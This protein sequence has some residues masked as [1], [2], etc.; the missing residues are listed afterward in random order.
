MK[1][2]EE[3]SLEKEKNVKTTSQET[4]IP[5]RAFLST[6]ISLFRSSH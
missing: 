3:A 6:L 2:K 4:P 1:E 5:S